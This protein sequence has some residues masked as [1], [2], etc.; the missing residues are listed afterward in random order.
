MNDESVSYRYIRKRES[1][2]ARVRVNC[3]V[4]KRFGASA[5]GVRS[6]VFLLITGN[7]LSDL[8]KH[9]ALLDLLLHIVANL[10]GL[11]KG[12]LIEQSPL[13]II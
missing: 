6:R 8:C 9:S 7:F 2:C 10:L 3:V 4:E 11:D 13:P 5:L 1:C 12:L